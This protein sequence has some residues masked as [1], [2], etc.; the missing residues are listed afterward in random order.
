VTNSYTGV[1]T[2]FARTALEGGVIDIYED[3]QIVR[4]FVHVE[5]VVAAVTSAMQREAATTLDV[6]SGAAVTI[7]QVAELVA[8]MT[9]A[10]PPVTSG[11]YRPG[12]VRAASCDI[13]QTRAQLGYA[14]AWSLEAGVRSLLDWMP[15]TNLITGPR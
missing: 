1:L 14:P 9:G 13:S 7:A 10:P 15:T 2:F 8:S 12:D 4:D 5:D 6:G 3:G 11:R